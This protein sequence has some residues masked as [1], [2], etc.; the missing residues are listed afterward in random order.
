MNHFWLQ[1]DNFHKPKLK[2]C[3]M[4]WA[5]STHTHIHTH[6]HTHTHGPYTWFIY[7]TSRSVPHVLNH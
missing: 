5:E 2:K 3:T 7:S 1:Y 4:P 6:T